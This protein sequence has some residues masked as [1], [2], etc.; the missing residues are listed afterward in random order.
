MPVDRVMAHMCYVLLS[1]VATPLINSLNFALV[2]FRLTWKAAL[3]LEFTP[4]SDYGLAQTSGRKAPLF[5]QRY[6]FRLNFTMNEHA[7]IYNNVTAL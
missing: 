5:R 7:I 1:C 2:V 3:Y 4:N 6:T